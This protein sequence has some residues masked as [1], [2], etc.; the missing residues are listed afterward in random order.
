MCIYGYKYIIYVYICIYICMHVSTLISVLMMFFLAL[1]T[2]ALF[3]S[4]LLR[5]PLQM[6]VCAM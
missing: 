4:L 2:F 1:E 5:K 6:C 3:L